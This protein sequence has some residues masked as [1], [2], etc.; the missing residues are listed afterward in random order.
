MQKKQRRIGKIKQDEKNGQVY[1]LR[2]KEKS[3]KDSR[4]KFFFK[5]ILSVLECPWMQLWRS[6]NLAGFTTV[7]GWDLKFLKILLYDIAIDENKMLAKYIIF[8]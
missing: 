7:I 6:Q 3:G 5:N 1:Q 2:K 8:I 4:R